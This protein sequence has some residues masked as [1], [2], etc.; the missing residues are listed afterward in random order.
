MN[1]TLVYPASPYSHHEPAV[2][3]WRFQAV[4]QAAA[5][6]MRL[7]YGVFCPIAHSHPIA[8]LGIPSDWDFWR[9]QDERILE[10]CDEL[11]VLMPDGRQESKGVAEEMQLARRLGKSVEFV[12]PLD[13]G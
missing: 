8:K 5:N 12:S 2:R 1:K 3:E 4:C 6:I 13:L 10:V 7:G 11:R 9:E